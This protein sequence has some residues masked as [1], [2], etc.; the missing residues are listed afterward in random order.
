M[1]DLVI[2]GL[3]G[4]VLGAVLVAFISTIVRRRLKASHEA[5][6]AEYRGSLIELREERSS[7]KETNR[8]LRHELA[9]NTPEGLA[10]TAAEARVARDSAVVDRD[11]AVQQ[12]ELAKADLEQASTRL[13]DRESKLREY[14]EALQEIRIS[15][16]SKDSGSQTPASS[17]AVEQE[18]I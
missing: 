5:E 6:A 13:A 14:R 2:G 12:L 8:K 9:A 3:L 10:A 7:D 18:A 1:S 16:E 17:D 11:Q 4:F 15:L